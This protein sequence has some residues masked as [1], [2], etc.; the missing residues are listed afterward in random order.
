MHVVDALHGF[1]LDR[2]TQ[3]RS[4]WTIIWYEQRLG[5]LVRWLQEQGVSDLEDVTATHLRAFVV[6]L[7][8]MP[9][10]QIHPNKHST[11]ARLSPQTVHGYVR[12]LRAFF[13]WCVGEDLLKSDP[14]RRVARPKL[15]RYLIPTFQPEHLAAMFD[16][17]DLKTALGFRNY[18]LLLV[19]LDTGIRL[20]ELCYLTLDHVNDTYLVVI[21]KGD[22]EREVGFGPTT[23]KALW[24]YIHKFR[25]PKHEEEGRMFLTHDGLPMTPRGIYEVF[26][27]MRAKAGIEG[28]RL[29]PHTF[30][31]TMARM[32]LENGGEVFKLSRVLGHASVTVTEV[33]LKDFQARNARA[34]SARFSPVESLKK[35]NRG[36]RTK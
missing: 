8:Q 1:L 26:L 12:A 32:W 3:N 31:H 34:E 25:K 17:C 19:L 22:K 30:R 5:H 18:A 11:D 36:D 13:A 24:K 29:S 16:T 6:H 27:Q 4:E 9:A 14:A 33:Y 7:Q 23:A 15:P 21:G 28:V 20:S 35:R 2:R 10:Y